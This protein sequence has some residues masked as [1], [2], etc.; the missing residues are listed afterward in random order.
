MAS[1]LWKT[2]SRK[3][4]DDDQGGKSE[5]ARV[6]NIFDLTALGVGAT[7]G[8][9][10]YV[11][12]GSVAK[13]TAGPAVCISFLIAAIASAFAGMCYAEFAS[14]VPKAGSAYV[15]SYVTVGEFIAFV[16]GW[17]LILE[18]VIGTAS[19]A[20]G[21]S[22]YIDAL[23]GNVMGKT[24][25]SIMPIDISFLSEYPDFFAFGMVMLLVLLLSIGVKESSFLNNIFTIINIVTIIIVIVAGAIKADP[26][27]WNISVE[28]IPKNV[29]HGGNGGF[30]PFGIS[31]VMA[32]A[33]KCFYGFVG[34]DA[35]ATTGEEAKKPQRDIPLAIVLSLAIILA[36]YFS[37]STV[38]TMM[39]PYYDQNADAPFPYVFQQIGW[40]V[41]QWIVNI[42]A[43]F[44]LCTSLLGAMFPLPR[45]LYAMA[46]DGIIFMWLSKVHSKTMTPILG[47]VLSGLLAGIMT[48]FFNLQQLIDMMSIGTLLAYTVVAISVLILRYQKDDV[49]EITMND[50]KFTALNI[51]KQTFNLNNH[52]EP[53]HISNVVSKC[54]I[55][56]FSLIVFILILILNNT[57]FNMTDDNV[58]VFVIMI[59][60]IFII[61]LNVASIGRQPVQQIELSFKVPLVPLIPCCSIFINLYLM[62]QL[63]MFTWIRFIV[64]MLIGFFIYLFYGIS[65]SVQG[66]KNKIEDKIMKQKNADHSRIVTKF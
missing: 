1:R 52:K 40:P 8:L 45:V 16:I 22:N 33:A 38:L 35:V 34:F 4:V 48:L 58:I 21:L 46:S 26:K 31:G 49:P 57:E 60:L 54:S 47:T 43:I 41:I 13:E 53:S 15:Y 27:N 62:L 28:D 29:T 9:G 63:D 66:K 7:L 65:H 59:I 14:R 64:W 61:I 44:A 37:I 55:A 12:A 42:G 51:F 18:Y 19:V 2:L 36:A 3:R 23:I 50:Y 24:L 20:R 10:V 56:S 6:L 30:M 39:W 17:N 11:L 25:Y 32:G 5:L